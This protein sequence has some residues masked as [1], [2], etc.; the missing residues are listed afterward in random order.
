MLKK[1]MALAVTGLCTGFFAFSSLEGTE[2]CSPFWDNCETCE[3]CYRCWFDAEYLYWKFKDS[4]E[5]V[6]LIVASPGPSN[7]VVLG[8]K[9]VDTN[10]R[11]GGSFTLGFWFDDSHRLGGD[12]NYSFL[13]SQSKTK[14]VR[15]DGLPGSSFLSAPFFNVLTGMEDATGVAYP[16][17]FSGTAKLALKNKMQS[18]EVNLIAPL[19]LDCSWNLG[20]L[21]GF[22]YW[23][24]D[25]ELSFKTNSPYLPPI[26]DVFKT[27][28]N[29]HTENN[30]YG[31]QIGAKIDFFTHRYFGSLKGKIA[32]GAMHRE[33]AIHGKLL[34]NDFDGFGVVQEFPGGYFALPTNIGKRKNDCFAIIPEV[35]IDLGY[36]FSDDAIFKIGY[37]FLYVSHVFWAGDEIDRE[38]NPS[39]SAVIDYV[40]NPVLVGEPRPKARMKSSGFWAQGLNV[41][42]EFYF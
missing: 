32:L 34:T 14:T 11:S 6:P 35:N 38:I 10:W 18:L 8:G 25:E 31:G 20:L 42:V 7:D 12:I 1:M 16:G 36:R 3:E 33:V 37:T 27:K 28:D 4:P 21:A 13:P 29:F 30:F 22:R 9:K 5:P 17:S 26:A 40:P 2:F 39:Q 24:F 15:S 41:G 23:N 19:A